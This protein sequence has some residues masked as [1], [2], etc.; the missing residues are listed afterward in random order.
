MSEFITDFRTKNPQ[1][2]DMADDDLVGAL[3]TKFYSDIPIEQFSER[4]GYQPPAE[5]SFIQAS[6]R[7]Q[8]VAP[9]Q[10]G[11][12]ASSDL[13]IQEPQRL[14]TQEPS[15]PMGQ[16]V[17]EKFE[18][19]GGG[20]S[21]AGQNII[22]QF[23]SQLGGLMQTLETPLLTQ[24]EF[25]NNDQR[26]IINDIPMKFETYEEY[27]KAHEQTQGLGSY[28]AQ[29]GKE[30][31]ESA[32]GEI[33]PSTAKVGSPEYYV[34]QGVSSILNMVPMLAV[35]IAGKR[36]D[37]GLG[38]M[39]AQVEGDAYGSGREAGLSTQDAKAYATYQAVA[40]VIPSA[41]P[42]GKLLAGSGILTQ[43]IS[44][45]AQE[46]VTAGLQAAI[47]KGYIN[48]EMTWGEASQ[49]LKDAAIIGAGSGATL[50]LATKPFV[51]KE[52]S[53]TDDPLKA[54][55][56]EMEKEAASKDIK[57]FATQAFDKQTANVIVQDQIEEQEA[58][59]ETLPA[60]EKAE[61]KQI[62]P[63][64]VE[65]DI[66]QKPI[67]KP[68]VS[69][70]EP[71]TVELPKEE[72]TTDLEKVT[73]TPEKVTIP[74]KKVTISAEKFT[75][76][77]EKFTTTGIELKKMPESIASGPMVFKPKPIKGKLY[78]ETNIEGLTSLLR[79]TLS[80]TVEQGAVTSLFV[81]DSPDLALG[82]KRNVGVKIQFD[83][84]LVSGEKNIKPGTGIGGVT[85]NEYKTDYINRNAIES[86]TIPKGVKLKGV[87][88]VFAKQ[89]FNKIDN[90]NGSTT[91]TRKD[92][93]DKQQ[94][95]AGLE[96]IT[97]A[98]KLPTKKRKVFGWDRVELSK[99]YTANELNNWIE[100]LS[101]DPDNKNLAGGIQLLDKKTQK[102][103][104]DLSWAVTYHIQKGTE[105]KETTQVEDQAKEKKELETLK[106]TKKTPISKVIESMG[107]KTLTDK[108][109]VKTDESKQAY[110]KEPIQDYNNF[111][112]SV[113]SQT[114]TAK[115]IKEDAENLI[116]NKEKVIAAMSERKFTKAMLQKITYSPRNDLTKPQM[117]K[118]AY[119]RML[120]AHVMADATITVFGGSQSF[121]EQII[122]Q[123][124]NQTQADVD[125]AYEKQREYRAKRQQQLE[126]FKKSLANPETLP[127]FKEFIRVRGKAKMTPE[128]LAAYDELVSESLKPEDRPVVV[129]GETETIKTERAQTTHTKTGDDLFV[130]KMVGR[131][132]KDKFRELNSK[133]KQFGGYYSSYSKGEAI[134]GFQFKTVE[135]ADQFEKLLSGEDIDKSD[136]TEAK[137]EVKQSKNA[138][139]LLDMADK[140]EAKA[141]EEL[142]RPR[143]ANTAR[144]AS[145]AAGATEKAEKQLA[146]AGTVRNIGSRLQDGEL[147]HLGKMSQVTQLEELISIQKR[148]IPNDLYEHGS[149]DGYSIN[150][151]LK[152][153]VTINDY[154]ANI[155]LPR[156]ELSKSII[157]NVS[158][159]LKGKRG[160]TRL[161]AELKKLP[162]GKS[163]SLVLLSKEQAEKIMSATKD[164][165]LES[166]SLSWLPDQLN[167]LNRLNKL[168]ITTEEQLRAAIRELDSMR[169][170]AKGPDPVKKLERELIG[171]KIEGYF[172]TPKPVVNKMIDYA[173]IE[174]GH[175]VL[176]P[177]AGSGHI[178]TEI[179]NASPDAILS[180]IEYNSGLNAILEAKGF[181]V[182]GSDFLEHTK[183]YDRI[184]M[185]PP[186][187]NFQDIDHVKHAYELLKPGGKIVA[188]MGASVKNS[189]SK[190]VEF[191]EWLDNMGSYIEDL[192][193]G[194]FKT[195]DRPTGVST[196]M[197]T[198]EKNDTNTLNS[199]NADKNYNKKNT[200]PT[201]KGERI[202]H[203]PGHNYIGMFR[204]TG[205]P[206]RREFVSIEN[207]KLSIPK[208]PQ[209]IEPIMRK[210]V[211][212]MGRRIYN[213]KI[214]GKSTEG[215]YRPDIGEIRT[216]KKN[217]VEVLAHE[218]AH[219]LDYYSNVTLP[220]FK[221]LYKE[222]QFKNEIESL[223]YTDADDKIMLIEG[224]AEFTRLWLTNS[225]EALIRA[226]KFYD[227][228]TTLLARDRKLLNPMR[229]MQDLMHRFYFQGADKLGQALMGSEP[230]F[231][232][233]FGQWMFR[234]DARIGAELFDRMRPS[235]WNNRSGGRARQQTI[236]RFHAARVVEQKL[237]GKIG[238]VQDSSWKQFR[239]AN[240]GSEGISDYI[241]NYG[242]VNFD[243]KGDLKSSGKS[244]HDVL[245]PVKSIKLNAAH[246][247]EQKIDVLLRYFAGRRA[248]ELHRQG[249][250]NLIPKE[251]ALEWARLG[252]QYP[253]FES[254]Q[255]EYQAFN[256]RMMDF[257]EEAGMIT[258]EGR[259][260]MKSMNS[261]YVPFNR[262]RDQL[263]GGKTGGSG[264]IQRLKGGTANLN[265]ILVNMQD[266]I[267]ANVRAALMNK[268]K[269]RLYQY[270][271]NHRDGAI[272]ATKIAPDSKPVKVYADEMQS[273]IGKVLAANGI[274]VEGDLDLTG[275]D[276]LT[277]WQHG[278][279]P[280]VNE[281]G[282]VVDQVVIDGKPRYYEVQDPLLQEMLLSMNPESY[283]S[284][285][286]IMFGVKNFFTRSITLGVEFTGANLVRD[287]IGAT[288]LSKNNFV[289]FV[290]SFKGMYS[291]FAKDKYYQDFV[292]SGGG[293]S[294]RLEASTREGTARRRVSIDEFGIMSMPE[295]LLSS[296]DNLASAFEYGTRIGEFR[297]AKKNTKSSMD[298]AFEAREISTDFAA[299]G[300]NRFLTGYIRTVPFLNAMIQSQDRVFR[301]AAVSKRY[302]G[303]PTGM[304][305]KAFLGITVP[306]L[307]LYLVNKDDD[308]YKNIPD[309][310]KRTN[311]HIKI[312]EDR[313]IKIPRPYDVGFVY[314]TMPEL[315]MKYTE[316]D[317]GKEFADGMIWTLTQMYGIDGVPA[318]M[319]GWWD[320]VRNEKWTGAPVVPSSLAD[321]EATQQYT[322]NTSETFVRMGQALGVSPIK[323][324]HMFKAYTGYL[325]GYLMW[326]TD[327]MLWDEKRF[328]EKPD[329]KP[330]DNIFLKRFLTP[331]VRPSSSAMEKFFKIKEESDRVVATY[332]QT[333]DLRRSIK[334]QMKD[335][336]KFKSDRFYGLSAKEK[337]VLFALNDSMNKII[338][339]L[340]GKKGMKTA[341]LAI[342]YDKD[343]SGSGKRNKIDNIW[344][345]KNKVFL[346]Y[347]S[348][349]DL[350][351]QKAKR[352]AKKEK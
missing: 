196:V 174:A 273:K 32:K 336:G 40:E 57:D 60:E 255:K 107:D 117:V 222:P 328:G 316:D 178:A 21:R 136:F 231:S 303:N 94:Q 189:R 11:Y 12:G 14:D 170:A 327:H 4:I 152:Q 145:M 235:S 99:N 153:G 332:K 274:E 92:L 118:Q 262:I 339:L 351:L 207:R 276:L 317:K 36:P 159:Q 25:S 35:S 162:K 127:E 218:L 143:Q 181:N 101:N 197:V 223:S 205:I 296:I 83:G 80:N 306:T 88:N 141:T 28:I 238:S 20:I 100:E 309:Y 300:A 19:I 242:T 270:I 283:G 247:G 337:E 203:A 220:N 230:S 71:V 173:D 193:E 109:K 289:P 179:K 121:E 3:H 345:T 177:S 237:T 105:K 72:V 46:V 349:A 53:Y 150:R 31:R 352:E 227:A 245:A 206:E 134:P 154:V 299:I 305:M 285:M 166:Y 2:N 6:P 295:K 200:K 156:I 294:G 147:N 27:S 135:S 82:Q 287:T 272:F 183:K 320:L 47:D 192:P 38:I 126:D 138:Q 201:P 77:K 259:K 319:T 264:G 263:A 291:F 106:E 253:I 312:G 214:K 284:F 324:E 286:N 330:S 269:Q 114:A 252:K 137:A 217:D 69:E 119:E 87:S 268:S 281:S 140:M 171:K 188:I 185:N 112:E 108:D 44:E 155:K 110:S 130:V 342:K 1:Y 78:R 128:Q 232:T 293:Y 234:R 213:G 260:S 348:Q 75:T 233:R 51:S 37:I 98:E 212:I 157:D 266:G 15:K 236:D 191:R 290:D 243:E 199:K 275:S 79:E 321:V 318:M 341:E 335:E 81:A 265:D 169:V 139:K 115:G 229:D 24:E 91:Y 96:P 133:A 202:F 43:S 50:A 258:P 160:Y 261:D 211:Q 257:Y 256:D 165:I 59:K 250:E 280:T 61:E 16:L 85:G 302:D 198:I 70:Q 249:R 26:G 204:S 120:S 187:E 123:V 215:F 297:L 176:E 239:L 151:P 65:I 329:S 68:I 116:K 102:K 56:V 180:V 271:S 182:V 33:K 64:D 331:D 208:E 41:M 251:T 323:A 246:K 90:S 216:R 73:T 282:N 148:A 10:T 311:W 30:L 350:A 74:D 325:G 22:P 164:K 190:A 221:K 172:P 340:Y 149:Y 228:F 346:H 307:L 48:P 104:D 248:L 5:D 17:A 322:S 241:L 66:E 52:E 240:G 67:D 225:Q 8:E 343:L 304:A 209:R 39:L 310:E 146:L 144:R 244:L 338:K 344:K 254:I 314:A 277:F 308:D 210:L 76:P 301:E 125:Q 45:G 58:A 186:F 184:V 95:P 161:S 54:V 279:K 298:A 42:L 315:F 111:Q 168:G 167:T 334:G 278:V 333:V 347:Y 89:Q 267:T 93:S 13:P 103:I 224:F 86:F 132:E 313:F 62:K 84:E 219:Y 142:T 55:A 129:T 29:K 158:E 97:S 131:V 49:R 175:E 34:E 63:E 292:R 226:P 326:G 163:E 18:A 23:K 113:G 124:R 7:P 195:S 194:S 9:I 288:F 122:E